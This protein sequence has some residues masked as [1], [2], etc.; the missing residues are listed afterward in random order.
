MEIAIGLSLHDQIDYE[1]KHFP[2]KPISIVNQRREETLADEEVNNIQDEEWLSGR[3][4]NAA[5]TIL[6]AQFQDT[7]ALFNAEWLSTKEGFNSTLQQQGIQIV[8]V[9][10]AHWILIFKGFFGYKFVS[11]LDSGDNSERIPMEAVL[12]ASQIWKQDG[13]TIS[14]AKIQCQRQQDGF[15]CGV[16]AVAFAT[17]LLHGQHPGTV[18]FD[19]HR[20]RDHFKECLLMK[21]FSP[22][23]LINKEDKSVAINPQ[24]SYQ[25]YCTCREAYSEYGT[26]PT[27]VQCC[28]CNSWYHKECDNIPARVANPSSRVKWKCSACKKK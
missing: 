2:D 6:R 12:A 17:A 13:E 5:S 9:G 7:G 26:K 22:F 27:M 18:T 23:P 16:F 15:N 1:K 8:N 25:L 4:I 14:I 10:N 3:I 21:H 24:Q 19:V 20:M 11:V 28:L